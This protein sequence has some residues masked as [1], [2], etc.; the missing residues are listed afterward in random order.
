MKSSFPRFLAACACL[1]F[2]LGCNPEVIAPTPV[3]ALT[4]TATETP[5][6]TWTP[7]PTATLTPLPTLTPSPTETPTFTPIPPLTVTYNLTWRCDPTTGQTIY[8]IEFNPSGGLPEY[9]YSSQTFLAQQGG[10]QQARVTSADGQTWEDKILVNPQ[11][12]S[13][14][15]TGGGSGG[16]GSTVSGGGSTTVETT[17]VPRGN[18]GKCKEDKDKDK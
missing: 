9:E 8:H 3:P 12:C 18:S 1:A 15:S 17:C 2:L 7:T 6:P 13:K 10:V 16:G 11:N 5:L 4:F 14:P